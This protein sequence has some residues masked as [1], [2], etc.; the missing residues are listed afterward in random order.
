MVPENLG[1]A[2]S[3]DSVQTTAPDSWSPASE[4]GRLDAEIVVPPSQ[5]GH[6]ESEGHLSCR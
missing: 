1:R 4:P 3:L 2:E 6:D 5:S